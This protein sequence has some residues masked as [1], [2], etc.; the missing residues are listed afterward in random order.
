MT[1]RSATVQPTPATGGLLTDHEVAEG[2]VRGD[3]QCLT[4]AYRRWGGLVHALA[5][6]TLGDPRE[7]EDVSQQVFLA[8]WRG[9]AGYRPERGAFPG[10]LIG[11]TRRKIADALAER[12]RRLAL[13]A[14]AGAALPPPDEPGAGPEAVL[15]RLVVTGEL[16]RL[17]RP[18]RE[19]LAMAFY[20]DLTQ[21]QI[22]ERTG[23]PLGT[24][25][26]HTRRGL[27]RMRHRFAAGT[28]AADP[29]VAG[30]A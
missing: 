18:Q 23:M 20:G 28:A 3:E 24:V 12:T 9:R 1:A 29:A 5:A 27:H 8:A 2:F 19:V 25:K 10:W 7:A 21:I 6:R 30:Y 22:A 26:S 16:A 4:A 14:A 11:I 13:V 15:D 17:P